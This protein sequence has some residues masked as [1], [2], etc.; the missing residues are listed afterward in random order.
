[1]RRSR[2]LWLAA[3]VLPAS[4][5]PVLAQSDSRLTLFGVSDVGIRR[6]DNGGAR[7]TTLSADGNTPSRFGLRGTEDLGGGLWSGFWLEAGFDPSTGQPASPGKFFNRRSTVSLG[8]NTWGE[9]RLGRDYTP[10]FQGYVL[11][12]PFFTSGVG[13]AFNVLAGPALSNGSG[14]MTTVRADNAV[15]WLSPPGW[16]GFNAQVMVAPSEG[17][18]A[19]DY[20][21]ARV[22]YAT[23]PLDASASWGSTQV[24]GGRYRIGTIGATYRIEALKLSAFGISTAFAGR[25]EWLRLVGASYV[26][27]AGEIRLSLAV[28]DARG[29]GTDGNDA[30]Q[31]A[32]GYV[33]NLSRRTALYTTASWLRNRAASASVVAIGTSVVAGQP[34][35]GLEFG[36]RHAF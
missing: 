21:G 19:S 22:G 11:Y 12:D 20:H 17:V 27:G 18:P 15:Q 13:A 33:H 3:A 29:A 32:L 25:R 7:Q 24:P 9:L 31:F 4:S 36:V 5:G 28:K 6:T 26:V 34:S 30:R 23:G 35:R 10:T 1:M 8:D 14:A 16:G 2:A